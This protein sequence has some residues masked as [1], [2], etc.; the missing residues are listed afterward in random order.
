MRK[1]WRI[2]PH[3]CEISE[4]YSHLF[5]RFSIKLNKVETSVKKLASLIFYVVTLE[6]DVQKQQ[7]KQWQK[8]GVVNV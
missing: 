2:G 5:L 7:K 1:F 6:R 8:I 3:A 4:N